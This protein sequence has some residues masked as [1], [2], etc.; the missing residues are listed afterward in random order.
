MA[1]RACG[2]DDRYA[3]SQA[4]LIHIN[5]L[6]AEEPIEAELVTEHVI[7]APVQP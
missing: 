6:D 3:S 4:L 1:R 2:L 5:K 7:E